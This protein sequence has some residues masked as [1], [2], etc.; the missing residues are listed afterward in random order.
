MFQACSAQTKLNATLTF[1]EA[2]IST[3]FRINVRLMFLNSTLSHRIASL[4]WVIIGVKLSVYSFEKWF[5]LHFIN[6]NNALHSPRQYSKYYWLHHQYA[7][8]HICVYWNVNAVRCLRRGPDQKE[9]KRKKQ[10]K[11][12]SVTISNVHKREISI[13]STSCIGHIANWTKNKKKAKNIGNKIIHIHFVMT[14]NDVI[15][16]N[17]IVWLRLLIFRVN[18]QCLSVKSPNEIKKTKKWRRRRR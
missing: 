12:K 9:R 1:L 17:R 16:R 6:E 10:K 14:S 15:R 2:F 8:V 13:D 3:I 11:K 5:I 7:H 18:D 4:L